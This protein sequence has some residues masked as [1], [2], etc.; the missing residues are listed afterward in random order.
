MSKLTSL[1]IKQQCFLQAGKSQELAT[2]GLKADLLY[3]EAFEN[4]VVI[5]YTGCT[6]LWDR[7]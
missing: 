1:G 4:Y 6:P 3:D 5:L 2:T 7:A